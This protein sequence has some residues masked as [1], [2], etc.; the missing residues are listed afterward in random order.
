MVVQLVEERRDRAAL[1]RGLTI[2]LLTFRMFLASI[3]RYQI[4][5]LKLLTCRAP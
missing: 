2:F 3:S 5:L 4:P 1:I